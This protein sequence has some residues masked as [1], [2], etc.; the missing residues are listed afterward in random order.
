MNF[1]LLHTT[2]KFHT[3]FEFKSKYIF[4]NVGTNI[5]ELYLS[6]SSL[7]IFGWHQVLPYYEKGVRMW[8]SASSIDTFMKYKWKYDCW[9]QVLFW[10]QVLQYSIYTINI[11]GIKFWFGYASRL[12][13][14]SFVNHNIFK[15][16]K[17][18][19][20]WWSHSI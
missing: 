1:R 13:A 19:W 4:D 8:L 17:S 5:N 2:L 11:V 15:K 12:L 6:A 10:H 20:D 14:S 16:G 9:H 3:D 7:D 18:S